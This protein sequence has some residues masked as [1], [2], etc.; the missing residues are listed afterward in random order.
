MKF[1]ISQKKLRDFG[2]LLG[3]GFPIIIGWFFS[4][5]AGHDFRVWT[6]WIGMPFLTLGVYKP[7]LLTIPYKLWMAIGLILGWVNSKIILGL[8]FIIIVLPISFFMKFF[9][10]DP[11]QIKKSDKES[12]REDKQ[13]YKINLKKIF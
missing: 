12:F 9:G 13:N 10:Y 2:L 1:S 8:V 5:L 7:K 11:L 4:S 3:L 6:I